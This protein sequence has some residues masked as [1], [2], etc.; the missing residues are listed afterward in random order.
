MKPMLNHLYRLLPAILVWLVPLTHSEAEVLEIKAFSIGYGQWVAYS[1]KS[2]SN[3][4]LK[5]FI[6]QYLLAGKWPRGVY[7][8]DDAGVLL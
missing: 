1:E 6:G 4:Q 7:R 5:P 8:P 3:E 2:I